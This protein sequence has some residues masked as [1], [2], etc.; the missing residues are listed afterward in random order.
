MSIGGNNSKAMQ[1]VFQNIRALSPEFRNQ[2]L[3]SDS[4][5]RKYTGL[6]ALADIRSQRVLKRK[7]LGGQRDPAG[8]R[9]PLSPMAGSA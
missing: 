7:S 9:V 6:P 8:S 2:I 3:A 1:G 5:Y 4:L